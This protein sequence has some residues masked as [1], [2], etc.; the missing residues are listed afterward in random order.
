MKKLNLKKHTISNLQLRQITG[1]VKDSCTPTC[2]IGKSKE[3]VCL[4]TINGGP[5]QTFTIR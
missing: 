5:K 2:H 1:G 3:G 4:P